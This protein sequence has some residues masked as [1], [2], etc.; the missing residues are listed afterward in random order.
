MKKS[1][2]AIAVLILCIA[3]PTG[4]AYSQDPVTEAIKQ[5]IIKV[6]KAIDLQVQRIQT[7]TIWLQN[8]QKVVENKMSELKLNEITDWVEKQKQLYQD[9]FDELAKV[10]E[11]ISGYSEVKGIIARQKQIVAEYKQA[12]GVFR[13]DKNFS[14]DEIS[15]MY[16]VYS[17]ILEES[18]KNVDQLFL[19]VGSFSTKMGD[20]KRLDIIHKV[21][22]DIEINL[23]DL[24][25]F[26]TQN[27]IVGLQRA[28]EKK[29][30]DQIRKL[31]GLPN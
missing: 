13:E 16:K 29:D 17:G 10:K 19:V 28:N 6:I 21:A 24:R 18:V 11:V 9:Y 27:K 5:G 14:P 12:Y 8:A 2:V 26:N 4:V 23:N 22:A 30:I 31:Y 25:Q 1:V 20:A 7:R 15:Y 3:A